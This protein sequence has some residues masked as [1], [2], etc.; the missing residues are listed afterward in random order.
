MSFESMGSSYAHIYSRLY[1]F[2]LTNCIN[3]QPPPPP[4]PHT[5]THTDT[6]P[7]PISATNPN[8]ERMYDVIG[9]KTII[10][11]MTTPEEIELT[12]NA[13]YAITHPL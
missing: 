3:K 6:H 7:V 4:P 10:K 8:D 9:D 12:S 5:H 11:T 1:A 13:A 2:S